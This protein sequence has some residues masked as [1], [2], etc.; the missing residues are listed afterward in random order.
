[1]VRFLKWAL[2][3]FIAYPSFM[4]A[5]PDETAKRFH[6]FPQLADGD[7]WKSSLLVTNVSQ[8]A[9][10]CTFNL[11]GMDVDRFA[12]I[13]G[14]T[15]S[16]STATFDLEESGDYLVWGSKNEL[17]VATGYSTLDCSAP[18]VAQ[19]LYAFTDQLGE[20]AGMATV[21]SSQIAAIFQ[22]PV[23][24]QGAL[25]FAIAND[26]DSDASCD[27]VLESLDRLNLGDATLAV[28]SKSKVAKFLSEVVQIPAGF[29]EG[30]TTVS[31]DQQVSTIGLQIDGT[32][33]TT[34]P[35]SVLSTTTPGQMGAAPQQS[36][37]GG[38][39]IVNEDI[40]PGRYFT[41]PFPGCYWERLS[42]TTGSSS[43][44]I[45]NEFIGFDS[46]QEIIDIARSDYA[47]KPDFECGMW[48]QTPLAAPLSGIPPGRWLVGGQIPAGMYETNSSSG[49]YWE[50][51]SGF[52][53]NTSD[54]IANDFVADPGREI[55]RIL[56]SDEGF[57]SDADCGTWSRRNGSA[58]MV[59]NAAPETIELN[60]RMYRAKIGL[61]REV[62]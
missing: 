15:A 38:T 49:C 32:I 58:L 59:S 10:Q 44:I 14:I 22:F 45:A 31:C 2:L 37:G 42:D 56:P 9:S 53:G 28:P 62:P 54:V 13:S 43:E 29:T 35:A 48:R 1:M 30:S 4:L 33:F 27:F 23:L 34:L 36:F 25:A 21:F 20:T 11:Y 8:S 18:V 47:F 5:Q 55:V 24:A 50:R 51:L 41:K 7:G 61:L 57:Y 17:S 12:D 52:N 3:L 6:V 46:G 60:L 26:A 40:E 39:W 19:V 16:G